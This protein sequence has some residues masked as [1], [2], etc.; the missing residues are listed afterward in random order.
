MGNISIRAGYVC[1]LYD[2]CA[3]K[4][5]VTQNVRIRTDCGVV[6]VSK[7]SGVYMFL[8]DVGASMRL[9]I[10]ADGYQPYSRQVVCSRDGLSRDVCWLIP[11]THGHGGQES[12]VMS[13]LEPGAEYDVFIKCHESI[14]RLKSDA[15]KGDDHIT[16]Y[17]RQGRMF[18]GRSLLLL[19][20]GS[21]D[22]CTYKVTES[23][24]NG[25]VNVC[26]LASGLGL[27][28][29]LD[30]TR[31]YKGYCVCADDGGGACLPL[32]YKPQGD[33]KVAIYRGN[34][35]QQAASYRLT[36]GGRA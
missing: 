22:G 23:V 13:G 31:V 35:L 6:P 15:A 21:D 33:F 8:G 10:E 16:L 26:R 17:A 9:D 28:Y 5:I 1:V 24:Q 2:I 4:P 29:E 18:L 27:A 14:I 3:E 7:G 30:T 11:D 20:S 19:Q 12:L 25:S 34:E 36:R 32:P